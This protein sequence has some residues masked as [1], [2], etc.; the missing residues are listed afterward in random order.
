[1]ATRG[2]ISRQATAAGIV[3]LICGTGVLAPMWLL[4]AT[5]RG[6]PGWGDFTATTVGDTLLLPVLGSCLVASFLY[7]PASGTRREKWVLLA[8]GF[9]GF[10]GGA[11]LQLTWVLDDRPRLTWVLPRPHHL[12]FAGWYH[13]AHMEEQSR[14]AGRESRNFFCNMFP[15]VSASEERETDRGMFWSEDGPAT[16]GDWAKV[17]TVHQS[18]LNIIA[19][20][21]SLVSLIGSF[22]IISGITIDLASKAKSMTAVPPHKL[23]VRF[24]G[25]VASRYQRSDVESAGQGFASVRRCRHE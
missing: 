16:Q 17:L 22:G 1:L 9:I 2:A 6:V 5:P 3:I 25:F 4:G 19:T 14:K 23:C 12:S 20:A 21:F 15:V 24:P 11:V 18:H 13:V 8:G 10:I 7:L